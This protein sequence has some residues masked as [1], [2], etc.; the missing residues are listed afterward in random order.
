MA[1][2]N[3]GNNIESEIVELS[4]QIEEKRQQLEAK[5]DIVDERDLVSGAIRAH[6]A[7]DGDEDLLSQALTGASVGPKP[8][9]KSDDYLDTLDPVSA[10]IVSQYIYQLPANGIKKTVETVKKEHPYIVD[11]FHDALVTR[12]YDE[13]KTRGLIK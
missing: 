8:V 4:R 11:A 7:S 2:K 10:D 5:A 6:T 9:G 1:E 13:L 3:F 12:L